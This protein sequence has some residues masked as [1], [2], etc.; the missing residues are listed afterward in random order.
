MKPL[1]LPLFMVLALIPPASAE[2]E[3]PAPPAG[4]PGPE[5]ARPEF[6]TGRVIARVVTRHDREQSYALYL[7]KAYTPERKWPILY[8]FSPAARGT[9][10]V[11]LFQAAAEKHGWIVV[12]SNNSQNGPHEPIQK[13]IDAMLKDT[14]ARL[15]IDEKRRYATG[16]SGGAR[17]AFFLASDQGFAGVLPSG[18][19]M[20]SYIKPPEKGSRLVVAAMVGDKD[21]NYQELLRL[22]ETLGRLELRTRLAV[23]DGEHRWPPPE[24]AA[25]ALRYAELVARLDAGAAAEEATAALFREEAAA[26]GRQSEVKG[27]YL[28]GHDQLAALAALA[29]GSGAEKELAEKLAAVEASERYRKEKEA[30]EALEKLVGEHAGA[31]K[32]DEAFAV[33]MEAFRKFAADHPDTDAGARSNAAVLG[34]G[35]RM[36]MGG[37][38]LH[39]NKRYAEAAVWLRRARLLYP[40]DANVAYN[41]ACAQAMAGDK[42][43]ALKTFAE[44][45]ELGFRDKAHI[46]KDPD[47]E[48]LRETP[49]YKKAM[50][51]LGEA[52]PGK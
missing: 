7:P 8:G 41:L 52:P 32:S 9:D 14:G 6:E 50:E 40:K 21:F 33:A 35:Y 30:L 29:K 19:G 23:F 15:A 16:F 36:A 13:A 46:E 12:G 49:E 28:R 20:A 51:G 42:E 39:Q 47:L 48:S 34:A 5:A 3:A 43:Q 11:R 17:V 1:A 4:P 18:A 2:E 24:L 31:E 26:A 37:S 44:A 27:Q 10:P 22:E 38:Q 25:S 45:V